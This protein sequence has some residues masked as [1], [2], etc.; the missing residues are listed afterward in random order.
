L[1]IVSLAVNFCQSDDKVE[2]NHRRSHR[3][4]QQCFSSCNLKLWNWPR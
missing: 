1:K 2:S 4:L 3:P